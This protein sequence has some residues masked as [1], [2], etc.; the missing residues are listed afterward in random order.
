[1]RHR[2]QEEPGDPCF[3]RFLPGEPVAAIRQPEQ[4]KREGDGRRSATYEVKEQAKETD[5]VALHGI[6]LVLLLH[7]RVA[8]HRERFSGDV[9]HPTSSRKQPKGSA[10][11]Q[12]G[13]DEE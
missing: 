3:E 7:R 1:D 11:A 13:K 8:E 5:G 12:E 9:R 6:F 10:Q 2:Y 4:G